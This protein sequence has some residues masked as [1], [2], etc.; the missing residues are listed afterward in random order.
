MAPELLYFHMFKEKK[1]KFNKEKADIFSVGMT[2]LRYI[3]S[4]CES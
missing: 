4:L 2:F 1:G 3:L